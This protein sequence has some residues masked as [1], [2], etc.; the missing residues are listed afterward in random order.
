MIRYISNNL[1]SFELDD[2]QKKPVFPCERGGNHCI[3]DLYLPSHDV[4]ELGLPI[5][6]WPRTINT[7]DGIF[8]LDCF[9]SSSADFISAKML[10][11]LGFLRYPSLMKVIKIGGSNDAKTRRTAFSYLSRNFDKLYKDYDP[12]KYETM[13]FIP[14]VSDGAE[15]VG[16]YK[17]VRSYYYFIL[18]FCS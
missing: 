10:S 11:K 17:D 2:V 13:P 5:L 1:S 3:T 15:C 4:R 6:A 8:S 9:P 12:S 18:N 16:A 7:D 14:V